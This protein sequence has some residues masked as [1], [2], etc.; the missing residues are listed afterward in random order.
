MVPLA[1]VRELIY[2]MQ[3]TYSVGRIEAKRGGLAELRAEM[4]EKHDL[5]AHRIAD[6]FFRIANAS[7]ATC[8]DPTLAIVK[9]KK[10]IRELDE[11]SIAD[12]KA[13]PGDGNEFFEG[14]KKFI[15]RTETLVEFVSLLE[16]CGIRLGEDEQ[17]KSPAEV[18]GLGGIGLGETS[19]KTSLRKI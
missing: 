11:K 16:C 8:E 19:F 17:L 14:T 15:W 9:A 13:V 1:P 2:G 6:S 5:V 12:W 4:D 3:R 18:S 10:A 7:A